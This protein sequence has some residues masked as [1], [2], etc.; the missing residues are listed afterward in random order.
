MGSD[1][2]TNAAGV[3]QGMSSMVEGE[4]NEG[5]LLFGNSVVGA[6]DPQPP[7][8]PPGVRDGGGGSGQSDG[9]DRAYRLFG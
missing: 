8:A 7:P 9:M 6:E 4:Q 2:P 1:T 3:A 5:D